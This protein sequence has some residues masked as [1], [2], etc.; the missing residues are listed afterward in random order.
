MFYEK[1]SVSTLIDI[2]TVGFNVYKK[3]EVND[4]MSVT[5]YIQFTFTNTLMGISAFENVTLS[6]RI[7]K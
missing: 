6:I 5:S 2:S 4:K 1:K 3:R 7:A